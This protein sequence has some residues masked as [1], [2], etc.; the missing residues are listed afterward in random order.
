MAVAMVL[1]RSLGFDEIPPYGPNPGEA[2]AF[3]EKRL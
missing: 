3:F 2:I 1:Y